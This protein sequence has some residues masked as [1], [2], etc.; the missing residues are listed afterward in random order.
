MSSSSPSLKVLPA[1]DFDSNGGK[2]AVVT[3]ESGTVTQ[4]NV[5]VSGKLTVEFLKEGLNTRWFFKCIG[6]GSGIKFGE[7]KI[8]FG[9]RELL[10]E[11]YS[12]ANTGISGFVI[13]SVTCGTEHKLS[14]VTTH[15]QEFPYFKF[16]EESCR[17]V[18]AQKIKPL[19]VDMNHDGLKVTLCS[20]RGIKEANGFKGLMKVTALAE[21]SQSRIPVLIEQMH[22]FL[23]FAF[24]GW[25]SPAFTSGGNSKYEKFY[26]HFENYP[27]DK[28]RNLK[29]W[30][31]NGQQRCLA[32]AFPGF[33]DR[34][35]TEGWKE[36][37][38][39]AIKW[40]LGTLASTRESNEQKMSYAQIPL[41]MLAWQVFCDS[42]DVIPEGEFEKLSAATKFSL[43]LNNAKVPT[44]IPT[45]LTNLLKVKAERSALNNGPKLIVKF[46]NTIIHPSK[47]KSKYLRDIENDCD[48]KL[49][50]VYREALYLYEWYTT[51]IILRLINYNGVY[52]KRFGNPW[53]P[54][55]EQV[56]WAN[57]G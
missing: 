40:L 3:E 34:F 17:Y 19:D 45:E 55:V 25:V 9:S 57:K 20:C 54:E 38:P 26:S 4:D 33:V 32:E 31:P 30:L 15:F 7:C 56:P 24:G 10:G 6:H 11:I 14:Q 35:T 48:V 27:S 5:S 28:A 42:N 41:E 46:R 2:I 52:A 29:G 21:F 53:N 12:I 36:P 39:K 18:V 8:K 22:Y 49:N 23:S 47:Q 51:M 44:C 1:L 43:L 13:D 50:D 37:L 16:Q